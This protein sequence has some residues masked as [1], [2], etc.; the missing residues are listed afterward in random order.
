[1]PIQFKTGNLKEQATWKAG[2]GGSVDVYV[3]GIR[4]RG[5]NLLKSY[6]G[7]SFYHFLVISCKIF[8]H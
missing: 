5:R 2:V 8:P 7:L 6:F 3:R 4:I 1:M